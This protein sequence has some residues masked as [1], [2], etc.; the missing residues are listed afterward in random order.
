MKVDNKNVLSDPPVTHEINFI[1]KDINKLRVKEGDRINIKFKNTNVSYLNGVILRYLPLTQKK[2]RKEKKEENAENEKTFMDRG[3]GF[4][5]LF[6]ALERVCQNTLW[7]F[8]LRRKALPVKKLR[9]LHPVQIYI[10][11]CFFF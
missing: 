2:E 9:R 4:K 3:S 7:K 5:T 6:V 1:D 10:P 11:L 8:S